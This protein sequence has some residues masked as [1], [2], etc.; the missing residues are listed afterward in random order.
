LVVVDVSIVSA[1]FGLFNYGKFAL[2]RSVLPRTAKIT[3]LPMSNVGGT[4]TPTISKG[5]PILA[6]WS[7]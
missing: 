5:K 6:Q 3:C 7:M 2:Y 4:S 1:G